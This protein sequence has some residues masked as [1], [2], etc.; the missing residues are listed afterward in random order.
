MNKSTSKNAPKAIFI[1]NLHDSTSFLDLHL[2]FSRFGAIQS[3]TIALKMTETKGHQ[4]G[5]GCVVFDDPAA[6]AKAKAE[7]DGFVYRG[8]PMVIGFERPSADWSN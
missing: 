4:I 6:A 8:K 1:T 7:M 5:Y 3:G 2:E